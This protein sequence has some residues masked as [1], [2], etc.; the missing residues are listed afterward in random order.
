MAEV[1]SAMNRPAATIS[2]PVTSS[3]GGMAAVLDAWAADEELA[4]EL[5]DVRK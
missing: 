4:A 3:S 1:I 2:A 5:E